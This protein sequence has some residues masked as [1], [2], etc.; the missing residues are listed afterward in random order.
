[1]HFLPII[2][3]INTQNEEKSLRNLNIDIY[4]KS[5]LIPYFLWPG[6]KEHTILSIRTSEMR[7]ADKRRR[8]LSDK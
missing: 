3:A 1:M 7:K 4:S 6:I 5:M 8:S 2:H